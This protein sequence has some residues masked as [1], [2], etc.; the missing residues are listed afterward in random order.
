MAKEAAMKALALDDSLSDAHAAVA[1]LSLRDW[2]WK[3]AEQEDQKA[4]ALNP[5]YV[6]AHL[7]YSNML[8]YLGRAE[9]S[10]AE[11][12]RAYELD[13]LAVLTNQV[14]ANAYLSA[15]RYDL[16]IAQCL[17]ALELHSEESDLFHILGWAYVYKGEY[18]KGKEAIVKRLAFDGIDQA[19]SPDLAYIYAQTGHRQEA[20]QI[21]N[22][23]L[24]LAKEAP[25][26][27][28]LIALI[29]AGLDQRKEALTLLEQAYR[30]HSP[31]M[32]WLK[33][34]PRFDAMRQEPR[35][36]ELMR[37]VGLI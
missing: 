31:M 37:S 27:P 34:D 5:G 28:G 17:S 24:T 2:D 9:E 35:F 30:Q 11:G 4:I 15:R 22:L 20:R 18:D 1:V 13:P 12:K 33:V 8:R 21:L 19:I 25:L 26:D 32:T 23:L 36:Q 10:I 6:T 7:S 16:A 14:L 3:T 29:H